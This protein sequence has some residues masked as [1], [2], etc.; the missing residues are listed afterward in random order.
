MLNENQKAAVEFKDGSCLVLA[1]PGSGKTTVI[2]RRIQALMKKGVKPENILVITFTR[3]AAKEMQDRFLKL[4]PTGGAVCFGTFHSIFYHILAKE[5]HYKAEDILNESTKKRILKDVL[6]KQNVKLSDDEGLELIFAGI[7]KMKG[8]GLTVDDL[9]E[10]EYGSFRAVD[11]S[12]A[13]F[14]R[15]VH[16]FQASLDSNHLIDFDDMVGKCYELFEDKLEMLKKYQDKFK[17]I[18]VDEAQDMST[19]QYKVVKML[20]LPQNNLY[21][22]GDDD[23][24]IYGFRGSD[25]TIMMNFKSDYEAATVIE[26][27]ENYRS[28]RDIL[29]KSKRL[30]ENNKS[31][32]N[33][34]ASPVRDEKGVVKITQYQDELI[35]AKNVI[36]IIKNE[37]ENGAQYKDIAILYRNHSLVERIE[38][39]LIAEKIPANIKRNDRKETCEVAKDILSYIDIAYKN[40]TREEFLR[41]MNKPDRRILRQSLDIEPVTLDGIKRYYVG[42]EYLLVLLDRWDMLNRNLIK[43][44]ASGA[45][46]LIGYSFGYENYLKRS[47]SQGLE[48]FCRLKEEAK[49]YKSLS[50]FRDYLVETIS[51][52]KQDKRHLDGK[53]N[54]VAL[55]TLHSSKGLEFK[56]VL[57]IQANE[58]FI[59]QKQCTSLDAIEEERR[60]FYVG[61]TRAKD[62]LYISTT[63]NSNGRPMIPSRFLDEL[64][65]RDVSSATRMG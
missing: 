29:E 50:A 6:R 42:D 18:M 10:K 19:L 62:S 30:I 39:L 56:V 26:L 15:I 53:N 47:Y 32:F 41:V 46:S 20:A 63:Q 57:I 24:S 36:G 14:K 21:I 34:N 31:R 52:G 16:E 23:Q 49:A 65:M 54:A 43:L 40:G 3:A 37:V 28:C 2:T 44:S 12:L 22:V 48:A 60:L 58:G 55:H 61:M 27:S 51:G 59:P 4:D 64:D 8:L 17:Y 7:S 11:V 33:K 35:E 9:N 25:P 1:G 5:C 45:I 38:D 13:S